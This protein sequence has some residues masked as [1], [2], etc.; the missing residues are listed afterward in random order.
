M[1]KDFKHNSSGYFDPTAFEA[2]KRIDAE[3]RVSKLMSVIRYVTTL[4][5]FEIQGRITFVD[6]KTGRIY[7]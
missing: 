5:G 2:V 3:D 7:K 4:A 1:E 6:K